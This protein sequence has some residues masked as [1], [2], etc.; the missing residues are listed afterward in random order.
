M[1]GEG[2]KAPT[3]LPQDCDTPPVRRQGRLWPQSNEALADLSRAIELDPQYI[4]VFAERGQTYQLM[5]RYDK[6]VA[7]YTRS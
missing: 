3:R 5:E 7:D 1:T 6:A 2:A 4:W